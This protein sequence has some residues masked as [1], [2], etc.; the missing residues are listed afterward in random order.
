VLA[1]VDASLVEAV[2]AAV[3]DVEGVDEIHAVTGPYDLLVRMKGESV[4]RLLSRAL[5]D[6]S[7]IQGIQCTETLVSINLD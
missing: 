1:K 5:K 3:V 7:S 6:I 2:M 4:A